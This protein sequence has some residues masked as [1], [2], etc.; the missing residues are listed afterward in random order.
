M[1]GS[2]KFDKFLEL[3]NTS[4]TNVTRTGEVNDVPIFSSE[5]EVSNIKNNNC[6]F[7][8]APEMTES[9]AADV[10]M[11]LFIAEKNKK[12]IKK[13]T[14]KTTSK[15]VNK[16]NGK[17][18]VKSVSKTGQKNIKKTAGNSKVSNNSSSK[19]ALCKK[20]HEKWNSYFN[21]PLNLE[22]YKKLY[23]VIDDMKITISDREFD[24]KL[25]SS[26]KEQ[27][28]DQM[29][30][31]L[32]GES[33]LDPHSRKGPYNG[34]FH[35]GEDGLKDAKQWA[36]DNKD[37]KGMKGISSSI[38]L[39]SFRNLSGIKQLNYLI[40]YI[41][42]SKEYSKIG[43]DAKI[44]PAQAWVM[45]KSPFNGKDKNLIRAKNDSI[46]NVFKTSNIPPYD[47]VKKK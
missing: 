12:T 8:N 34:L 17:S 41:G 32:A 16:T 33:Q 39:N 26:K 30:A 43:K 45:I 42:K 35:L 3:F 28:F 40:A 38:N 1:F 21:T 10:G 11:D 47:N 36:K 24:R 14:K 5:A 9:E 6:V 18:T 20:M 7:L 31:I 44:T 46:K 29:I 22:F 15:S 37:V 4:D 2:I 13:S 25:Y 27:T 23:D 19:I